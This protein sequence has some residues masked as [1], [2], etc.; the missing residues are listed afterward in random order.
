MKTMMMKIMTKMT[1]MTKSRMDGAGIEA[2]GTAIMKMNAMVEGVT[3]ILEA[4]MIKTK[5]MMKVMSMM[6]RMTKKMMTG[7]EEEAMNMQVAV[8]A[9]VLGE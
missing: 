9:E 7:V 6:K 3:G 2:Q 1:I 5:I 8:P 4:N